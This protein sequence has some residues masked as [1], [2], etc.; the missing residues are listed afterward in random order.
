MWQ[1]SVINRRLLYLL[2]I[3]FSL[4][5]TDTFALTPDQVYDRVKDSIIVVK[6]YDDNGRLKGLGSGVMLP[7]GQFVTNYHV[8]KKGAQYSV[9]QGKNFFPAILEGKDPKK[10]ICILSAIGLNAKPATLGQAAN[11]KVGERVYAIGAPQ[12]LELSLSEGIVS[13]LRG[14]PPPYIQTTVAISVGSSGGGLFNAEGELVGITTGFLEDSQNLNFALPVEWVDELARATPPISGQIVNDKAS[15]TPEPGDGSKHDWENEVTTYLK[16]RDMHGMLALCRRWIQAEPGNATAWLSLGVANN[17]LGRFSAAVEA[18]QEAVRLKPD[19]AMAWY[20]LGVNYTNLGRYHEAIKAL[21]QGLRLKGNDAMAWFNLGVANDHLGRR[22]EAVE[23]YLKA[24]R[25]KPDYVDALTNL[26][27]EYVILGS[28]HEAIKAL[29]EALRLKPG[30]AI[31]WFSLGVANGHLGR[32]Q[33]AIEAYLK[34]IRLKPDYVDA[35]TMLGCE[36]ETIGSYREAIKTLRLALQ[37]KPDNTTAWLGLANAYLQSG[38]RTAALEAIQVLRR[39][40]PQEAEKILN[41][42]K[43]Q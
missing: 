3:L 37:F 42:I 35:L 9:G 31:A 25:L 29:R 23:T 40:D 1:L 7:S 34:A 14:G 41:L 38:N 2:F 24:I 13:Q 33:E 30:N 22:Q 5:A 32:H 11:L 20:K 43:N 16:V 39:Y 8:I 4:V 26:G 18:Y 36:Y 19:F 21:R 17:E 12:G 10:D 28:N 27:C 15:A 6:T